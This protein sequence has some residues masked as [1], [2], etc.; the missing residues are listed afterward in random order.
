MD[1]TFM[2]TEKTTAADI[3]IYICMKVSIE[4]VSNIVTDIHSCLRC[5]EQILLSGLLLYKVVV[6]H[7]SIWYATS[8]DV[9]IYSLFWRWRKLFGMS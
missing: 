3:F 5:I 2:N 6:W 4:K 1:Q 8:W 7:L 9:Y